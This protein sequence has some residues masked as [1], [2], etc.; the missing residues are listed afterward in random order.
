MKST[1]TQLTRDNILLW[2]EMAALR[3]S[4]LKQK[5]NIGKLVSFLMELGQSHAQKRMPHNQRIQLEDMDGPVQHYS[6]SSSQSNNCLAIQQSR[7]TASDCDI[8]D[9][10]QQDLSDSILPNPVSLNVE[11]ALLEGLQ[12]RKS[13][14]AHT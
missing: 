6:S 10:I 14:S 3:N 1:I 9:G 11:T 7:L 8:L 2:Q 13:P 5:E 4:Y 12:L